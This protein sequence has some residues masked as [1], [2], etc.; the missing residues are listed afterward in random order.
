[1]RMVALVGPE[2]G[3]V[4]LV[5]CTRD[6]RTK[7]I[8]PAASS[9]STGLSM[10][11]GEVRR[12]ALLTWASGAANPGVGSTSYPRTKYPRS[13][14]E[15]SARPSEKLTRDWGTSNFMR[16]WVPQNSQ[17]NWKAL[18]RAWVGDTVARAGLT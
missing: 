16:N 17:M 14:V 7:R 11:V 10:V 3:S 15:A 18:F 1:M 5:H 6:T 2:R 8:R 13:T 9:I 4:G 12:H